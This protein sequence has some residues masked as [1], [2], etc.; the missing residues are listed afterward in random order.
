VKRD[1]ATCQRWRRAYPDLWDRLYREAEAQLVIDAGAEAVLVLRNQLRADDDRVRRD[2]AQALLKLRD[3]ARP[4]D[5]PAADGD[6]GRVAAYLEGLD[7]AQVRE[8]L[9]ELDPGPAAGGPGAAAGDPP[10]EAVGR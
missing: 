10:G 2:A 7:D 8:L 6:A 9:G 1:P 4:D 3:A 5:P